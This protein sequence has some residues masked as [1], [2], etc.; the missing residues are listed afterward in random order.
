MD[1]KVWDNGVVRNATPE[2]LA[3]LETIPPPE[4]RRAAEAVAPEGAGK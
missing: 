2:E 1:Y 4:E 3:Q